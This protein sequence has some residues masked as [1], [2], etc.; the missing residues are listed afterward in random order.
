MTARVSWAWCRTP[1]LPQV[2]DQPGLTKQVLFA[3]DVFAIQRCLFCW[4]EG[5]DPTAQGDLTRGPQVGFSQQQEVVDNRSRSKG[6]GTH[7]QLSQAGSGAVQHDDCTLA[8]VVMEDQLT[9]A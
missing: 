6:R 7:A 5:R 1:F 4:V 9:M 3:M 2:L 8:A